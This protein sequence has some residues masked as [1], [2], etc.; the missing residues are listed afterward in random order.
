MIF[1]LLKTFI[2]FQYIQVIFKV[3]KKQLIKSIK[4]QFYYYLKQKH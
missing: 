2:T 4:K 3:I 1:K